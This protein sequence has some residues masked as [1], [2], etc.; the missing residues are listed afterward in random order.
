MQ[1]DSDFNLTVLLGCIV[2]AFFGYRHGGM[3]AAVD[4]S[5]VGF[6]VSAVSAAIIAEVSYA[7]W[8]LS[9][10][11][12]WLLDRMSPVITFGVLIVLAERYWA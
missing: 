1:E 5:F 8:Y 10:G 9:R 2:G 11:G 7:L 12:A 6:A 4:G 3:T